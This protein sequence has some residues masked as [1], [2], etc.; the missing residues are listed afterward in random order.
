MP[1]TKID[2]VLPPPRAPGQH[3]SRS[4]ASTR[5]PAGKGAAGWWRRV[6]SGHPR[7]CPLTQG[8]PHSH[9]VSLPPQPHGGVIRARQAKLARCGGAIR[10]WTCQRPRG[11]GCLQPS[12][13]ARGGHGGAGAVTRSATATATGHLPVP[14]R[15][16]PH[17]TGAQCV[18]S[19]TAG[20]PRVRPRDTRAVQPRVRRGPVC[21][22]Y[23]AAPR[24]CRCPPGTPRAP[25]AAPGT[26][27]CPGP[28]VTVPP[29]L[30]P[31]TGRGGVGRAGGCQ[32][33]PG[34]PESRPAAG[35][36]RGSL[37]LGAPR[38]PPGS[39]PGPC[40]PRAARTCRRRSAGPCGGPRR[41]P[42]AAATRSPRPP[43]PGSAPAPA[44]AAVRG[45]PRSGRA[46]PGD[47]GLPPG[48]G[49]PP[50]G[51][52]PAPPGRR[53]TG[54]WPTRW[55]RAWPAAGTG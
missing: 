9:R 25:R 55:A 4:S 23:P 43:R 41:C 37:G 19:A 36:A 46:P 47:G 26:G 20:D 7:L 49:P 29:G 40:P 17:G 50:P 13:L 21:P 28:G 31:D 32:T 16:Q 5:C 11:R 52:P 30:Q 3:G 44:G 2:A 18:L 48:P 22:K 53:G 39:V 51:A 45:S 38:P 6:R 8:C 42:R 15:A 10:A 24:W 54:R 35:G 34:P 12:H 27:A 1:G 14:G 33:S